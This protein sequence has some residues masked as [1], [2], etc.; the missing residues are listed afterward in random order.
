MKILRVGDIKIGIDSEQREIMQIVNELYETFLIEKEDV[1]DVH[2]SVNLT[3]K[4]IA[5]EKIKYSKQKVLINKV[6]I[7]TKEIKLSSIFFKGRILLMEKKG[8]FYI[9]KSDMVIMK[10]AIEN[11]L[12]TL[13]S[14]LLSENN[15]FLLHASSVYTEEGGII[16]CGLSGAGKSTVA[17][18]SQEYTVL[19]DDQ[20]IIQLINDKFVVFASPFWGVFNRKTRN[21]LTRKDRLVWGK[22][23]KLYFL[24]KDT[25][26]FIK[27]VSQREFI[28]R[29]F[30]NIILF[31]PYESVKRKLFDLSVKL[32][33]QIPYYEL[34]FLPDK[35]FWEKIKENIS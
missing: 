9:Y 22:V 11:L 30:P 31:V 8:E 2:F 20:T 24:K 16:F 25:S 10:I 33:E 23:D 21:G 34:H 28:E 26:V 3:I 35:S 1:Q 29:L 6:L 32:M 27:S 18:F 5:E 15:G 14:F 19:T 4:K 7:N 12:R 13:A 17:K